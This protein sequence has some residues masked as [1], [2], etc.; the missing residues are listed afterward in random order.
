MNFEVPTIES[1]SDN[2]YSTDDIKIER[3][4]TVK[5]DYRKNGSIFDRKYYK[6]TIILNFKYVITDGSGNKAETPVLNINISKTEK[7]GL[8]DYLENF[9]S[10][11]SI[12]L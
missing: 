12:N 9:D 2:Y 3:M 6:D 1:V 4:I 8:D 11:K 10:T 5:Y 7:I